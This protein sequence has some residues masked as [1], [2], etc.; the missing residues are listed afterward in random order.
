MRRITLWMFST[1]AALVLLF[2]YRTSTNAVAEK[3]AAGTTNPDTQADAKTYVGET[4][5][6]KW[7]P[8]Q[9]GVVM[10]GD[11]IVDVHVMQHPTGNQRDE[12]INGRALPILREQ[13]LAAQ[14]A[15]V[16][17][18][19]GATFTSEGYRKSLQSALDAA[20]HR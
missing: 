14:S 1:V 2:S 17:A 15:D 13:T 11:R 3:V 19:S 7:G 9:V 6:V 8:V 4:V 16:D 5:R 12:E 18:V 10:A 20:H